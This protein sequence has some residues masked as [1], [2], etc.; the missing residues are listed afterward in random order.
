MKCLSKIGVGLLMT[1]LLVI[2]LGI[3]IGCVIVST[4]L[5]INGSSKINKVTWDVHFEKVRT[6]K[7][8]IDAIKPA[9]LDSNKTS[10]NFEVFLKNPGDY[11]EFLI[12]V[13]NDG[14][15][16]AKVGSEPILTGVSGKYQDYINYSVKYLDGS[17]IRA[18]DILNKGTE[19]TLVVRVELDDDVSFDMIPEERHSFNLGFSLSYIQK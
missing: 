17:K 13:V 14:R 11:Y 4:V 18:N 7:G 1:I 8:S 15:I 5:N 2:L 16:D 9:T 10:I 12:D 19:K 6:T 3:S